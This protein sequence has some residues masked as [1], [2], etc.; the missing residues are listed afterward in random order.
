MSVMMFSLPTKFPAF[1][2]VRLSNPCRFR[3]LRLVEEYLLSY[4]L[5]F[6][7]PTFTFSTTVVSGLFAA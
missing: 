6:T 5:C 3:A 7:G 1:Q 2:T 4:F